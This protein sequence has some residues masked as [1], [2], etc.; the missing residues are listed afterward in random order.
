MLPQLHF[1][2]HTFALQFLL[3]RPEG[4]VDIVVSNHYLHVFSLPF[5]YWGCKL[6]QEQVTYQIMGPVSIE[7]DKRMADM[8][9]Q[10]SR[11][12]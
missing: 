11:T 8:Y 3:Q 2:K 6:L 7:F 10:S 9:R 5:S 4:L 1:T 12:A